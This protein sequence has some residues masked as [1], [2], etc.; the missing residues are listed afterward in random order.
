MNNTV[1]HAWLLVIA[2]RIVRAVIRAQEAA[3]RRGV[4][5]YRVAALGLIPS[6]IKLLAHA[7]LP[8]FGGC[9]GRCVFLA[10]YFIFRALP[11]IAKQ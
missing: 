6:D 10:V 5:Q 4:M 11:K 8:T 2:C 3:L 1:P 9:V 7:M